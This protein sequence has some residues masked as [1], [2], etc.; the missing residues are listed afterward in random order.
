MIAPSILSSD[1]ANLEAEIKRLEENGA[2]WV[3]VDVMDGHFVPNLTIGAPVVKAIKPITSIPLDVHL[4]IDNPAK[5]VKDFALA[6]SDI[7]TFHYEA[8]KEKTFEVI[9]IIKSYGIKVGLSIKPNT[10]VNEIKPYLDLVDL[11]LVMTVEPG[12]GGQKFM[13]DCADKIIEIRAYTDKDLIIEVD[14]GI[15]AE[16][17]Q[18]CKKLGAN[19]LVAGNYVFSSDNMKEAIASLR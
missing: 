1:F 2:D 3:H 10:S 9:N 4:M 11:I 5:Y 8:T 6:G 14:G 16:T 13:K 15:N 12:F 19:A 18:Y 17:A 7:I